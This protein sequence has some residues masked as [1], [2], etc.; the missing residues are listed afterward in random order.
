M[1]LITSILFCCLFFSA[2]SQNRERE[3]YARTSHKKET[4]ILLNSFIKSLQIPKLKP[5]KKACKPYI[6][7]N[8][9]KISELAFEKA[10]RHAIHFKYPVLLTEIRQI[11][12]DNKDQIEYKIW[13]GLNRG[14]G[15]RPP[16]VNIVFPKDGSLPKVTN[17]KNL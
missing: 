16:S 9:E 13:I 3:G 14:M 5:S 12:I 15:V 6:T 1:R 2:F 10:H 11:N 8:E 7:D 17:V 4:L